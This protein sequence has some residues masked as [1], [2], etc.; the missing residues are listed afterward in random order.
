MNL[1]ICMT[2]T[3]KSSP[4][5]HNKSLSSF[6]QI[7]T[8]ENLGLAS[9]MHDRRHNSSYWLK[10]FL[11]ICWLPTNVFIY[12]NMVIEMTPLELAYACVK[13]SHFF[14]GVGTHPHLNLTKKVNSQ[15]VCSYLSLLVIHCAAF[16]LFCVLVNRKVASPA[17]AWI[18]HQTIFRAKRFSDHYSHSLADARVGSISALARHRS[19]GAYPSSRR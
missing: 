14:R 12:E 3:E 10:R 15:Q 19:S 11:S 16:E 7:Y 9:Q 1:V 13:Y 4:D 8:T 2:S 18:I 6:V 5:S 17:V